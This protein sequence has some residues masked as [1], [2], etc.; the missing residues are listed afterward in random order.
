MYQFYNMTTGNCLR[1]KFHIR[2][3][4][5][6][7]LKQVTVPMTLKRTSHC[8]YLMFMHTGWMNENLNGFLFSLLLKFVSLLI[9]FIILYLLYVSSQ[10]ISL[11]QLADF[12]LLGGFT[13]G[14][15]GSVLPYTDMQ[16]RILNLLEFNYYYKSYKINSNLLKPRICLLYKILAQ[17]EPW[18]LS[19][20]WIYFWILIMSSLIKFALDLIFSILLDSGFHLTTKHYYLKSDTIKLLLFIYAFMTIMKL[21]SI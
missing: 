4:I 18:F 1:N 10:L 13:N 16:I 12:L 2:I 11:S 20:L 17:T 5:I 14:I 19:L 3:Y 6:F 8:M 21:I 7:Y 9:V 15:N